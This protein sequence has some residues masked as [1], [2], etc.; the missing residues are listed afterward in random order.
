M[1]RQNYW[2]ASFAN[3]LV[4]QWINSN[5]LTGLAWQDVQLSKP[6]KTNGTWHSSTTDKNTVVRV[7]VLSGK[8]FTGTNYI[9]YNRESMDSYLQRCASLKN[10]PMTVGKVTKKS[11]LVRF[12]NLHVGLGLSPNEVV[13]GDV[14]MPE[15]GQRFTV[16]IDPT[17]ENL[18]YYEGADFEF[19]YGAEDTKAMVK[20]TDLSGLVYPSSDLTAAQAYAASYPMGFTEHFDV[21][22]KLTVDSE[23]DESIRDILNSKGFNFTM[24]PGDQSLSGAKII[25]AATNSDA[26]YANPA[27]KYVIAIRLAEDSAKL[28]GV[29]LMQYNEPFDFDSVPGDGEYIPV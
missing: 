15:Y 28:R 5:G 14:T 1:I 9:L 2:G 18:Q 27:Y 4:A 8:P 20:T 22:S 21:L 11:E 24:E 26:V 3:R 19:L 16:R 23:V 17:P 12:L 10:A 29:V 6:G 13:E 25:Y 7:T